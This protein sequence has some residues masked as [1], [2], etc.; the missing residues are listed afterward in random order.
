MTTKTRPEVVPML[1]LIVGQICLHACMAGVRVAAPL[2]ALAEGRSAFAVG[3]LL[4]L[5]AAGPIA[6]A[7]PAGR[8]ADRHGYHRP[9]RLAVGFSVAGGALACASQ[10]G[11]ALGA[12]ALLTGIGANTGLITIQRSAGRL[13]RTP[14]DRMRVFSWLGLAPA[15]ANMIGAVV[16]GLMI[17]LAGYRAAFAVLMLMPLAALACAR[18]VDADVAEAAPAGPERARR[19]AWALLGLPPL[20]RLLLV[21]WLLAASWDVHSFVLPVLGHE[22]G[23]SASLIGTLLGLFAGAVAMVRLIVPLLAHRLREGQVLFGAMLCVAAVLAAY[24]FAHAAPLMALCAVLL[25]LA[26]G[27]VQPMIMSTLHHV[28]PA[29]RHGEAIALRSMTINLASTAMPL[30]F[31]AGGAALG[32]GAMFWVMGAAVG[33][34]SLIARRV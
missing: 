20:R 22:R 34:G 30:L 10:H 5:F 24:P 26:L 7:L 1:A 11:L 16:A 27:S 18:W 28:T 6:T 31:G 12:A 3:L 14:A 32:A 19:A 29:D 8:L 17:D 9:L 21:N 15:L 2:A 33:A 13:A 4:A 23:M 25:G